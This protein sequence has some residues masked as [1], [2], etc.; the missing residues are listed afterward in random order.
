MSS[1][2]DDANSDYLPA[3]LDLAAINMFS[4]LL[5]KVGRVRFKWRRWH[6]AHEMRSERQVKRANVSGNYRR[7]ALASGRESILAGTLCNLF[8]HFAYSSTE[9]YIDADGRDCA[10]LECR[11]ERPSLLQRGHPKIMTCT[12]TRGHWRNY[13]ARLLNF[14][15]DSESADSVAF[16]LVPLPPPQWLQLW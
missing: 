11:K 9:R 13:S 6:C 2:V 10:P 12:M 14:P 5:V 16:A 3:C 8:L 1:I 15:G 4:Q 7:R